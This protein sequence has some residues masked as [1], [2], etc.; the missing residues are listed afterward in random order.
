MLILFV[1]LRPSS[2]IGPIDEFN[3]SSVES[4]DGSRQAGAVIE[5]FAEVLCL[6]SSSLW[7]IE[8]TSSTYHWQA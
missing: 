1:L 3:A 4:E 7:E 5:S 8:K 6:L 2:Q